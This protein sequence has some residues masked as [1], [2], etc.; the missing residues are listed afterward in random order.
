MI[1]VPDRFLL[2]VQSPDALQLSAILLSQLRDVAPFELTAVGVAVNEIV[3]DCDWSVCE[4]FSPH[5]A[6]EII[7]ARIAIS[8]L[9]SESSMYIFIKY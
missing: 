8:F 5:P 1:S 3:G 9:L 2:P 4:L 7:I 6:R